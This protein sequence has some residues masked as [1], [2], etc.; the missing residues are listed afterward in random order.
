MQVD[1]EAT[2]PKKRDCDKR[3]KVA[4]DMGEIKLALLA[5]MGTPGWGTGR[6]Y[7]PVIRANVV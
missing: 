6:M 7:R 4:V 2:P 1:T 3:T 5:D